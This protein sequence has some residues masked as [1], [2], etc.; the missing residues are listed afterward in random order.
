VTDVVL[1]EIVMPGLIEPDGLMVRERSV[2]TPGDGEALVEVEASGVSFAE[3]SM[4][5]GRYPGQPKFPFVPATGRRDS[6]SPAY[7]TIHVL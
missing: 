1:T 3:T 5:R 7:R 4:R 6:K 2:P